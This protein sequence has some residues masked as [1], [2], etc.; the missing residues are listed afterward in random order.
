MTKHE[1][2]SWIRATLDYP[3]KLAD[4]YDL[5]EEAFGEL[6]AVMDE[7]GSETVD[8]HEMATLILSIM[9]ETNAINEIEHQAGSA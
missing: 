1:F 5:D 7:D 6:F 8:I 4:D 2:K 9:G 3:K